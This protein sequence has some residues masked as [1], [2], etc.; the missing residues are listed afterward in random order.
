MQQNVL[1]MQHWMAALVIQCGYRFR[2]FAAAQEAQAL[3]MTSLSPTIISLM[4]LRF[5]SYRRNQPENKR[6]VSIP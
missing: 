5:H 1:G 4:A 3:G 6:A 2:A